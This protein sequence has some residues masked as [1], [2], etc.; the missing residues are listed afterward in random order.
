MLTDDE[1]RVIM[2]LHVEWQQA[3]HDYETLMLGAAERVMLAQ[4]GLAG[5]VLPLVQTI[6]ELQRQAIEQRQR[7][8]ELEDSLEA[9]AHDY[10]P[11]NG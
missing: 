11:R 9:W 5:Y 4:L 6:E 10:G 7:I 1:L 8:A 3:Q 2:R